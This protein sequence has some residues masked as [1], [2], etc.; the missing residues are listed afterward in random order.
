VRR[1]D[2]IFAL[3]L[4]LILFSTSAVFAEVQTR[5]RI[6]EASNLG[7]S[8]D[9][10]LRD[11]HDQLGNLFNF[12]SYR[13]LKDLNLNLVGNR[14]V[15]IPIHQGRSME[16]TLF[17]QYL[18]TVELRIRIRRDGMDVLNTQVRLAHGRTVL[19]GGPKHGEGVIILAVS[20][21]F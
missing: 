8:I 2:S 11:I 15:E 10:S 9:P 3:V 17:G 21:Q 7:A 12:T 6:I 4:V 19:I 16:V 1:I 20:G 18:K 5:V 13:L 14:P